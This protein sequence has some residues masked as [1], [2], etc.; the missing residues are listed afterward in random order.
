MDY[1]KLSG[2]WHQIMNTSPYEDAGLGQWLRDETDTDILPQ[3]GYVG[4]RYRPGGTLLL[5]QNPGRFRGKQK[6]TEDD[7]FYE[8]LKNMKEAVPS[9]LLAFHKLNQAFERAATSWHYYCK[10]LEPVL[11][12]IRLDLPDV[13]HLNLVKWRTKGRIKKGLYDLGWK[14][15][16][17]QIE[18]LAPSFIIVLGKG[19]KSAFD[20]R[21][22]GPA[23]LDVVRRTRGDK[24]EH[25]EIREALKRLRQRTNKLNK[26]A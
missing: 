20:K 7:P 19:A 16:C 14:Y 2:L 9:R 25:P 10:V 17:L 12:A 26:P 24:S 18:E 1:R 4:A 21:Y 11:G 3:P 8:A 22:R 13:A 6:D 15:T 23:D 5:A